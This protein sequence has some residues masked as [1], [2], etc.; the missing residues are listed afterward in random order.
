[1]GVMGVTVSY[2][3]GLLLGIHS[4]F[5]I[6]IT[7]LTPLS[8]YDG[9]KTGGGYPPIFAIYLLN[10]SFVLFS[11][12]FIFVKVKQRRFPFLKNKGNNL[13]ILLKQSR[14]GKVIVSPETT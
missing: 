11:S 2:L 9:I 5:L 1:M 13:A 3:L 14:V 8:P 4:S 10:L 12:F 6:S 7:P